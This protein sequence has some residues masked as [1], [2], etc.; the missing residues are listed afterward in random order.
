MAVLL[1]PWTMSSGELVAVALASRP[2][3]RS[4]GEPTGGLTTATS[5]FTL[6]DGSVLILPTSRMATVGGSAIV[7]AI[8]PDEPAGFGDWPEID[9]GAAEA[10]LAWLKAAE[11][12]IETPRHK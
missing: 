5:Y 4:F 1:G 3:T 11:E 8:Q 7:G 2:G 12:T 10:A 9:D 6:E